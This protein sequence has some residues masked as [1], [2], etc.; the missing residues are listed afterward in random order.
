MDSGDSGMDPKI[1]AFVEAKLSEQKQELKQDFD[2]KLSAQKQEQKQEL[3]AKL[4]AQKQEQKQDFDAKLSEQKQ[5]FADQKEEF[6]SKLSD[7]KS[8]VD[9]LVDSRLNY[10]NAGEVSSVG[11]TSGPRSVRDAKKLEK[12]DVRKFGVCMACKGNGSLFGGL[13]IAH[14]VAD[15]GYS[16]RSTSYTDFGKTSDYVDDI[17]PGCKS[18]YLLLCGTQGQAGSCHNEYD[19]LKMSLYWDHR[20]HL[21]KWFTPHSSTFTGGCPPPGCSVSTTVWTTAEIGEK[22]TR[23]LAWRT[24][25][26]V[27]QPGVAAFATVGERSQFIDFLKETEVQE[28]N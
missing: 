14:I 24:M 2:S 15:L 10:W 16:K 4:S 5:E 13:T 8:I 19:L 22:Y 1:L 26:T 7:M 27:L 11:S 28:F 3:D 18:N 25:R 6:D 23:L 9:N 12:D 17:D 21:Y 20:D